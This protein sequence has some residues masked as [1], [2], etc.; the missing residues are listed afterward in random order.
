MFIVAP[1][2][3]VRLPPLEEEINSLRYSHTM[4]YYTVVN[5]QATE[6]TTCVNFSCMKLSGEKKN[7]IPEKHIQYNLFST[8]FK[9]KHLNNILLRHTYILNKT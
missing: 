6:P 8:K 2:I 9:N 7:Q 5:E 1:F 3:I 4:Q